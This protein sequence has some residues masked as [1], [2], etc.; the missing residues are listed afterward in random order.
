MLTLVWQVNLAARMEQ[1]GSASAVHVS[2]PFHDLVALPESVWCEKKTVAVKNLG[3][4]K[5]WLFDP[6]APALA[7][8]N[9]HMDSRDVEAEGNGGANGGTAD[10]RRR[11]PEGE[12]ARAGSSG[13]EAAGLLRCTVPFQESRSRLAYA[14]SE[15]GDAGLDES[16]EDDGAAP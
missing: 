11:R 8:Q 4:I 10:E 14:S 16:D 7:L 15:E 5:T 6:F 12:F 13:A 1:S 3:Q 9:S 2:E